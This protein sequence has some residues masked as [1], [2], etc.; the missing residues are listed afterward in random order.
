MI[1]GGDSKSISEVLK[2]MIKK[3]SWEAPL[4]LAQIQEQWGGW[5][6]AA[7]SAETE[8]IQLSKN[9]LVVKIKSSVARNAL[10]LQKTDVLNRIQEDLQTDAIT[11]LRLI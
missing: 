6:G 5:V 9:T 10:S 1:L 4:V 2:A 3:Q 11:D 7:I 8:R